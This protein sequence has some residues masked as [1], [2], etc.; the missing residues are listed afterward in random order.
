VSSLRPAARR[1]LLAALLTGPRRTRLGR[2]SDAELLLFTV[3]AGAPRRLVGV[4]GDGDWRLG[5]V[6]ADGGLA[7]LHYRWNKVEHAGVT[8]GEV[9]GE[10]SAAER[11]LQELVARW[12]ARGRPTLADFEVRVA[13]GRAP[14]GVEWRLPTAGEA[15]MGVSIRRRSG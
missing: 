12:S 10:A 1:R 15:R 8:S 11:D 2:G 13:F 4:A 14:R 3:C 5:L 6:D 7:A 9:Y